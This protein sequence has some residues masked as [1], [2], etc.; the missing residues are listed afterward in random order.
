MRNNLIK[1]GRDV[2]RQRSGIS[3]GSIPSSLLCNI[4]YAELE[5]TVL[6]YSQPTE[7]LLMRLTD[8]FLLITTDSGQATRFL[9]VMLRG[10]LTYGVAVNLT[11][12]IGNFTAAV[13]GIHIPRLEGKSL[14]PYC[15]MI[16]THSNPN[17]IVTRYLMAGN[18]SL[19]ISQML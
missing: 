7:S 17:T 9:Q 14:S 8:E 4:F 2:Y 5:R 16:N 12:S 18:L 19:S 6:G 3:Q 1:M 13:D 11:K 10:Q 15:E